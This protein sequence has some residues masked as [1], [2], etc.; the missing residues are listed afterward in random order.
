[1]ILNGHPESLEEITL[2]KDTG[3][4]LYLETGPIKE[5]DMMITDKDRH[6][7]IDMTSMID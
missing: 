3:E 1:M 5:A 4:D 2:K 6:M 7:K